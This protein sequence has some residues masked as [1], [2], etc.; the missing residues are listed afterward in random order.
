MEFE[1]LHRAQPTAGALVAGA[2]GLLTQRIR[3]SHVPAH[4]TPPPTRGA[5]HRWAVELAL[6][7]AYVIYMYWS[8]PDLALHCSI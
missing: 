8:T 3:P 5:K 6:G 7:L 4:G 2:L 1:A